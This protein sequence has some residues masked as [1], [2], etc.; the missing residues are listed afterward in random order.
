MRSDLLWGLGSMSIAALGLGPFLTGFLVVELYSLVT[1]W[2]RQVRRAGSSGRSRLNQWAMRL[3]LLVAVVQAVA[4]MMALSRIVTA[5]GLSV[6]SDPGPLARIVIL[7]TLV[8]ASFAV[9]ALASLV[10]TKGLGNGFCLLL[11]VDQL[12]GGATSWLSLPVAVGSEISVRLVHLI[13]AGIVA[14]IFVHLYRSALKAGR[15]GGEGEQQ[16]EE[17]RRLV[18]P[19]FPQ[20]L[21]PAVWTLGLLQLGALLPSTGGGNQPATL[22]PMYYL[23]GIVI[24]LP[25]LSL[26]T[27][28][29]FSSKYRMKDNLPD[30]LMPRD[31]ETALDRRFYGSTAVL[32]VL[33]A[34][35]AAL[36][37][38]TTPSTLLD[39]LF[40]AT[41]AAIATDL[42]TEWS[43][44]RRHG[45]VEKLVELDNVHLAL[46]LREDFESRG[47]DCRVQA[48]HYRGLVYFFGPL[49]KMGVL[50]SADH[51]EAARARLEELDPQFV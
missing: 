49:F 27:V 24:L 23:V 10:S 9:Y 29:L 19:S 6:L 5:G 14:A 46:Q 3:S 39:V 33:A 12:I 35:L 40:V 41:V 37:I 48:M 2:G 13:V 28:R 22:A 4:M 38:Y 42:V 30:A 11:L 43:F 34:A 1:P 15:G 50:V 7:V 25:L 26:L 17:E 45:A 31:F 51:L 21:V 8:A 16:G 32:T 47:I 44:R 18:L 36:A 20:G